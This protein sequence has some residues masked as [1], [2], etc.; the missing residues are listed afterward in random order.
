MIRRKLEFSIV[1][2][3]GAFGEEPIGPQDL[4]TLK[5]YRASC[6]IVK[7][8]SPS[9]DQA[10][11][12]IFGVNRSLMN[13]LTR[14]GCPVDEMRRNLINVQAG[15]DD[16]GMST[17]FSGVI[18]PPTYG[19]FDNVPETCLTI[20]AMGAGLEMV[21]PVLPLSYTGATSIPV[22]VAQ[23]AASMGKGFIN[24]GVTGTLAN[25]YMPGTA[26]DQLKAVA[27][28][29]NF[30]WALDGGQ[31]SQTVSIWP[32]DASRGE[33]GPVIGPGAGLVGYP[34]Y[35]DIGVAIT[36]LYLPGLAFGVNFTL[37]TEIEPAR[38][39]WNIQ[40]MVYDLVSETPGGAWFIDI[41]AQRIGLVQR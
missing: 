25:P 27:D 6:N 23:I 33:Y 5:G 9:V 15:D 34:R 11:I 26:V 39:V 12:R 41:E 40:H 10:V 16:A 28:A 3:K 8:G 21:K 30:Y 17:V 14:Y 22:I 2:G 7:A 37:D 1:L 4:V 18:L 32:K 35:S 31:D 20:T 29:G 38:G 13:Q 19:D 36:T 24:Y